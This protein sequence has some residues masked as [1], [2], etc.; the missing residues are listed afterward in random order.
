MAVVGTVKHY[1]RDS[2]VDGFGYEV[3]DRIPEWK[4]DMVRKNNFDSRNSFVYRE[5]VR[6]LKDHL[7]RKRGRATSY[8]T[9]KYSL[10]D[11]HIPRIARDIGLYLLKGLL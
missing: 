11:L 3:W 8:Y 4:W 10:S 5:S 6:A 1:E 2:K 9:P 7:D